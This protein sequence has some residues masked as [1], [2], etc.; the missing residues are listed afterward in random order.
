MQLYGPLK[1]A[2]PLEGS[3]APAAQRW[4]GAAAASA[5]Q[6]AACLATPFTGQ[7]QNLGEIVRSK[8][9]QLAADQEL[10]TQLRSG[11]RCRPGQP[12]CPAALLSLLPGMLCLHVVIPLHK[13]TRA[14]LTSAAL[15]CSSSCLRTPMPCMSACGTAIIALWTAVAGK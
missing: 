10:K 5:Q 12:G 13:G 7:D 14:S 8:V 9:D 15:R 6:F 2:P 11:Q 3:D 4:T 1:R